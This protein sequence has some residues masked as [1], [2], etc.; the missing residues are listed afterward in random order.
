MLSLEYILKVGRMI[1]QTGGYDRPEDYLSLNQRPPNNL[2]YKKS[3]SGSKLKLSY[4]EGS[5]GDLRI[6]QE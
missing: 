6:I 1:E 3:N 4:E 2:S 5:D